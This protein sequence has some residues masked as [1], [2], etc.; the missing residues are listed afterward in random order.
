MTI[1]PEPPAFGPANIAHR[2]D[3]GFGQEGDR[4]EHAS[5]QGDDAGILSDGRPLT[6]LEIRCSN[7]LWQVTRDG[8]FHGH[9]HADQLAFDAAE[10]V[11]LDVVA[12]GGAADLWW[13][14]P[15]P[16]SEDSVGGVALRGVSRIIEFR[17][18]ST[19]IVR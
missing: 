11:A 10:S 18:G 6:R 19:R 3:S 15:P 12:N 13:N 7:G 16:Q 14:D 2:L 17:S 4:T 1:D 5:R 8:R 9:Y